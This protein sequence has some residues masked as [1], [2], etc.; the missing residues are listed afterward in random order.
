MTPP[1][2]APESA[3]HQVVSTLEPGDAVGNEVLLL[4]RHLHA[5]GYAGDVFVAHRSGREPAAVRD[6]DALLEST[7]P[8]HAVLYH[9][10]TASTASERLAGAALPLVLVYHNVTPASFFWGVDRAH[11][12]ACVGAVDELRALRPSVR[13]AVAHSEFSRGELVALGYQHTVSVPLLLDVA[14]IDAPHHGPL[15]G[16]A[17]GGAPVLLSVGRV[18]PNK[19][20]EDTLRLQCALR[21]DGRDVRLWLA[22]DSTRLP[23][24]S[25]GLHD[26]AGR[27]GIADSVRWLG[28]VSRSELVDCYRGAAVYVS[29]SEHEGFGGTLVE[30]MRAGTPVVAFDAGAVAETV[31]GGGI[32]LRRKHIPVAAEMV[33]AVL[34]DDRLRRALGDAGQRRA[35]ELEPATAFAQL[36]HALHGAGLV[37]QAA[38]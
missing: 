17:T 36:L 9:F 15:Y 28:A 12:D 2:T 5:A 16:E 22:G 7:P 31:D 34:D 33:G 18:A 38:P 19:C 24:Y 32:L 13:L 27:L 1:A 20:L 26:M 3:V 14:D 23:A 29:M 8:P 21:R 37:E 10:A 11:H 6:L 30:A 35:A 25:D 4:Q